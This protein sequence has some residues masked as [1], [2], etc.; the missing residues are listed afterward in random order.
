MSILS[1]RC[2]YA[3]K[4]ILELTKHQGG[5]PVSI[6]EIAERQ[7]IPAR[8]LEAILRQLKHDGLTTS[9]RGKD[10]GYVLALPAKEIRVGDVVR[11]FR[12]GSSTITPSHDQADA[13]ARGVFDELAAKAE[14][15]VSEVFD[16]VTFDELASREERLNYVLNYTI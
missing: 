9:V 7:R 14:R 1:N 3:L 8:F 4:A 2:L 16:S 10:G 15:A 13:E 11:L 6:S 12:K 5:A